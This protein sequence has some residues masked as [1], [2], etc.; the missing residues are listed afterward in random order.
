MGWSTT[1]F[2]SLD[3]RPNFTPMQN[4][5]YLDPLIKCFPF[6]CSNLLILTCQEL[7]NEIL[8][9]NQATEPS[10]YLAVPIHTSPSDRK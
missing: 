7:Y 8:L 1:V 6:V 10:Q 3:K 4:N 9:D 5:K 2:F